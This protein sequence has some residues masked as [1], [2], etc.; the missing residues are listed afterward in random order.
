MRLSI[1][2]SASAFRSTS[3]DVEARDRPNYWNEINLKDCQKQAS[4]CRRLQVPSAHK[5]T[6]IVCRRGL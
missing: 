2:A 3:A 4:V 1:L 6:K 5:D